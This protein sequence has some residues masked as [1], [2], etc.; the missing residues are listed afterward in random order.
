MFNLLPQMNNT[1]DLIYILIVSPVALGLSF[2]AWKIKQ[3]KR[4][5]ASLPE[6]KP[7][8]YER[9]EMIPHFDEYTQ[10]IYNYKFYKG[11]ATK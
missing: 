3:Y 2:L 8:Q 10:T 4:D 6:A 11:R 7:F 9:D 5:I 1:M